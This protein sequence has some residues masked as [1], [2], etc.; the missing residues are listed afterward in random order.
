[1]H[2]VDL[3]GE[4]SRTCNTDVVSLQVALEFD[5]ARSDVVEVGL[6]DVDVAA[7]SA[8]TAA[9]HHLQHVRV[10]ADEAEVG[11]DA[12]AEALA[13]VERRLHQDDVGGRTA[14]AERLEVTVL[15]NLAT[16]RL[17]YAV[18]TTTPPQS[19][20]HAPLTMPRSLS[21]AKINVS[22]TKRLISLTDVDVFQILSALTAVLLLPTRFVI[23]VEHFVQSVCLCAS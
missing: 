19:S 1:M 20:S 23:Q 4:Q 22:Q 7:R 9:I 11:A 3:D 5:V 13:A 12:P 2:T 10:A 8:G 14:R 15:V 6:D 21:L 17:H 18:N 16:G